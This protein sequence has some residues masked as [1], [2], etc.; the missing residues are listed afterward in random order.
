MTLPRRDFLRNA[1]IAGIGGSALSADGTFSR[2]SSGA[3]PGHSDPQHGPQEV[4]GKATHSVLETDHPYI[5]IDSCMQMWPD[6]DFHLA[7]S[8][9]AM[10]RISWRSK[11]KVVDGT[12]FF[13]RWGRT[14]STTNRFFNQLIGDHTG[15]GT[16]AVSTGNAGEHALTLDLALKLRYASGYAVEPY[17]LLYLFEQYGGIDPEATG[18]IDH[19]EVMHE[20]VQVFQVETCNPHFHEEKGQEHVESMRRSSL[21][22]LY[23]SPIC[24][25]GLRDEIALFLDD[26]SDAREPP[27]PGPV[28]PLL[29]SVD[30]E[31]L[32][33]VI[34]EEAGSFEQIVHPEQGYGSGQPP[35]ALS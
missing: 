12:L 14:S 19:P 13:N 1:A 15:F 35:I 17:E 29:E 22:V 21:N 25:A 2:A 24:P 28:Y 6:A 34:A 23:H 7:H 8:P 33:A 16:E 4:H 10:V 31:V 32:L 9:Y 30:P 26:R 3:P 27:K 11:P 5:Y 20:G 18:P